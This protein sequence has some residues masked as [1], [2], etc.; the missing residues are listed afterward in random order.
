MS[1]ILK[2]NMMRNHLS[3][4]EKKI[5]DYI[6]KNPEEVKQLTTYEVAKICNTSQASIVRFAK[7]MGFSGYPDFKLSLSQDMGIRSVKKEI[8]IIDSEIT[9][10]DTM[11]EVCQKVSRENMKAIEDTYSLLEM[12]DLKKAVQMISKAKRIMILGA[13]FSGVVAKDLSYKLLELGKEVV[14]EADFHMQFSLLTTM[15]KKDLLFV[16]SYS[17]KT[18]EVYEITKQAKE[19]GIPIISLTSIAS[20]PIRELANISLNTVELGENVRATA[21]APR[22]SQMTLIDMIYVQLI[23]GNKEMEQNILDAMEIVKN[24]KL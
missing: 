17:G 14:F 19:R 24:F 8:S 11:T 23:L 13:G 18:K 5:A 20:N 3:K 10:G 12:N 22:I 2:L 21:L 16:I 15:K 9:P 1:V 4:I 7:K 6:L